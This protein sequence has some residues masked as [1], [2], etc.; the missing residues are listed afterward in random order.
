MK[1]SPTFQKLSHLKNKEMLQHFGL[2]FLINAVLFLALGLNI[3]FE[4]SND[5]VGSYFSSLITLVVI[6]YLPGQN[7]AAI[8]ERVTHQSFTLIEKLSLVAICSLL[9]PPSIFTFLANL[10]TAWLT[11]IPISFAAASWV[12]ASHI[13]PYF[14]ERQKK[15]ALNPHLV[16]GGIIIILILGIF[17]SQLTTAYYA[18]PDIDP[19]SWLQQF[20]QTF[21][22][23]LNFSFHQYRPLFI[24]LGYLFTQI[25]QIDTYAFFKYIIPLLSFFLLLPSFLVANKA[26]NLPQTLI[27]FS[28]PFASSSFLLYSTSS[29]PQSIANILLITGFY[30]ILYSAIVKRYFFFVLGG[31]SIFGAIFFHEANILFLIPW[32]IVVLL[33]NRASIKTFISREWLAC[34]FFIV[35]LLLSFD[36]FRIYLS[37]LAAWIQRTLHALFLFQTNLTFPATYIN[38]DGNAVGW[39]DFSGILRYYS[40][41]FGPFAVIATV[42]FISFFLKRKL[43][44]RS[45]LLSKDSI[46]KQVLSYFFLSFFLF[47]SIAELLPRFFNFALLPERALSF[48]AFIAVFLFGYILLQ[49][50][51]ST[52]FIPLLVL[53]AIIINLGGAIYINSIKQYLITPNQMSSAEWIS[54]NL[55]RN[56]ILFT[57]SQV[58]LLR[59]HA[60]TNTVIEVNDPSL[61][62]DIRVFEKAVDHIPS[63]NDRYQ[64][65]YQKLLE[66]VENKIY[67]LK[68]QTSPSSDHHTH[69]MFLL[70]ISNNIQSF[71][72]QYSENNV[73]ITIEDNKVPPLY[74][75]YS[76]ES[77]KNPYINR[78]YTKRSTHRKGDPIIFDQFPN[79]FKR[80]YSLPEDEVVIW[81][82]KL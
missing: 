29:L 25:A 56:R 64:T 1:V 46:E 5:A 79:R 4:V 38:I 72:R 22:T 76:K 36:T 63:V 55:P 16:P 11:Y 48:V 41:Y 75:Y 8:I 31:V 82:T 13:A 45:C 54:L 81:E 9:V 39:S 44:F 32:I 23:S 73:S 71:L 24:S 10:N 57:T 18:L 37:F 17:V 40:F 68:K 42:L 47:F 66:D 49:S 59:F 33:A 62:T 78:P 74:I 26:S 77:P 21:S 52:I 53:T 27:I 15:E 60:Q 30:F 19:Y 28:L 6:F 2:L 20:Q 50:T 70:G 12:I 58:N 67:F 3:I 69:L 61:Y 80:V 43:K 35:I 7:V 65:N 14:W 34:L 51:Q